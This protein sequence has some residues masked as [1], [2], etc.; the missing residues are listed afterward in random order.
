[1]TR[2]YGAIGGLWLGLLFL[3]L[4]L[5]YAKCNL[6]GIAL[7]GTAR[8]DAPE[9]DG[10]G[11][12]VGEVGVT[13]HEQ[14]SG[15]INR[16]GGYLKFVGRYFGL[17]EEDSR[18]TLSEPCVLAIHIFLMLAIVHNP[19]LWDSYHHEFEH[20]QQ[21][22]NRKTIEDYIPELKQVRDTLPEIAESDKDFHSKNTVI[23]VNGYWYDV[24]ALIPKH[25]GGPIIEK[26]IGADV[27]STFYG[28]H[29]HPEQILERRT[30]VARLKRDEDALRNAEINADYW[31][32]WHRY[33]EL[34]YFDPSMFWLAKTL[35]SIGVIVAVAIYSATHYPES[36]F[37]NAWLIS[38]CWTQPAYL[39]HDAVHRLVHT[40]TKVC[41]AI[42]FWAG[43]IMFGLN[44][45][46]WYLDHDPHHA[47]PNAWDRE[48]GEM[49]DL[50]MSDPD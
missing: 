23:A 16:N 48:S 35:A 49:F 5:G 31:N 21:P 32:L 46:W 28:M 2:R 50:Q 30:P 11:P 10:T 4:L 29:R 17:L 43:N 40:N 42:G 22:E 15:A 39:M 36:W 27:T 1:M 12:D 34:G 20:T 8:L 14:Q 47:A 44:A 41:Y 7:N 26:Y 33:K 38:L 45:H 25:P 9:G 37:C 13:P 24:E 6:S 3:V 18:F 19:L